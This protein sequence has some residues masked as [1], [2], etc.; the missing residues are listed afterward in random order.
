MR[1]R[2]SRGFLLV[3]LLSFAVGLEG[4]AASLLFGVL[5]GLVKG[6]SGVV[7]NKALADGLKGAG[8]A[9]DGVG[10]KFSAEQKTLDDKRKQDA[11]DADKKTKDEQEKQ[12][13]ARLTELEAQLKTLMEAKTAAASDELKKQLDAQIARVQDQIAIEKLRL[14]NINL[15]QAGIANPGKKKNK[16]ADPPPSDKPS[17]P[18]AGTP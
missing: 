2:M 1:A 5:G 8:T 13:R 17:A 14:G 18:P 12:K 4:C 11:I 9:I 6:L 10:E 15:G 3:L 7:K 16:P